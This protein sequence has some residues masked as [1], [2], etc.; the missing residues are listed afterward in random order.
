MS[1]AV[2]QKGDGIAEW[3]LAVRGGSQPPARASRFPPDQGA[4]S[5]EY[6]WYLEILQRWAGGK[7]PLA[8]RLD[9]HHG[10]L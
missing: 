3:L 8:A 5:L 7:G 9:F 6:R 1:I 4:R 2:S 10:L